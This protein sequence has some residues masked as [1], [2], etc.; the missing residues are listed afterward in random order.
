MKQILSDFVNL[1]YPKP[2]GE[3]WKWGEIVFVLG[4]IGLIILIYIVNN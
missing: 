1:I 3:I 4:L 2:K